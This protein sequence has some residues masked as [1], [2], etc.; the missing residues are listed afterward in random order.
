MIPALQKGLADVLVSCEAEGMAWP[1]IVCCAGANGYMLAMR[2]AGPGEP[3]EELAEH[4][5]PAPAR[6]LP[7]SLCR[8]TS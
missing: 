6:R 1:Y 7:A 8:S 5:E 2:Y 3:A 4:V